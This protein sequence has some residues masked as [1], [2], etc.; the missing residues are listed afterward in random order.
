MKFAA[1]PTRT[2]T[3]ITIVDRPG[4]IQSNIVLANLAIDRSNPDYFPVLVM[5]QI[6]GAGASSRLFMNLREAKGYTY[7]A[8][9][10][11]DTRRQAGNFQATAEVRTPVTGDSLKEFFYELKR[12]RDEKASEK[13]LKTRKVI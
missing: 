4:S 6:L 2:A 8:Y 10:S 3:T 11:F 12:V 13:E 5:N 1:P 9:S 7:G